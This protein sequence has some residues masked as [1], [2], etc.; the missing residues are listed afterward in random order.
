MENFSSKKEYQNLTEDQNKVLQEVN[1]ILRPRGVE[2][3]ANRQKKCMDYQVELRK[4]DIEPLN[5]IL[6]HRVIGSTPQDDIA[7]FDTPNN[8]IENFIRSLDK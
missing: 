6:W 8:D 7:E 4:K 3:F 1:N 5:Y 2:F